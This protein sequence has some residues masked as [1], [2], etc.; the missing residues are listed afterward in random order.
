MSA[1]EKLFNP[2]NQKF[3]NLFEEEAGNLREI[4]S[5][6][7][8]V[9]I[10]KDK[11]KR[12]E[13]IAKIEL[14]ERHNDKLTHKLISELAGNFITPFDREDIHA[15]SAALDSIAD[16]MLGVSKHFH[17]YNV[18]DAHKA[19][20]HVAEEMIRFSELLEQAIKG[21]RNR[22]ALHQLTDLCVELRG[23][24]SACDEVVD[25]EIADLFGRKLDRL[26]TI[27][28]MDHY[29]QLQEMLE[30]T[31]EAVNVLESMILKYG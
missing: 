14:L 9:A 15:L 27:I 8:N 24:T 12:K 17:N 26:K 22:R 4:S 20:V 19:T 23:V 7:K 13:L 21:L 11:E 31:G 10:E 16:Y 18:I 5:R 6:F 28:C 30:V 1:L 25:E 2:G 29:D 3:Y